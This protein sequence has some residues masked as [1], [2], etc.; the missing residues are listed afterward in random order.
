MSVDLS[1]LQGI[2]SRLE[3]VADRLEKGSGAPA[4]AATST[5]AVEDVPAIVSAWDA[6]LLEKANPIK[7]AADALGVADVS[8]ATDY[9]LRTTRLARDVFAATNK[10]RKPKD[11]EWQKFLAPVMEVNSAASKA[12]DNRSE[13]FGNRKA[14]AEAMGF[15]MMVTA[16]NPG[17]FAQ[18]ALESMDFHAI[19]VLQKKNPPETAWI[20]ALKTCLKGLTEWCNENCKL[21][22][23][24]KHDGEDPVA[25]FA[26]QPL[27]SEAAG[28]PKAKGK[29]KG[30]P[31][32]PQGGFKAPPKEY[33]E[34]VQNTGAP[35]AAASGA[36]MSDVFSAITE[37]GTGGLKKV[38]DDMKCK[39]RKDEPVK[40]VV[41][42]KAAAARPSVVARFAKGPKGPPLKELQKDVNW[43]IEN[44]DGDNNV[45]MTEDE[46]EMK[47]CICIINCRNTTVK[48]GS[49]VKAITLDGCEKVN[50]LMKDVISVVEL[51]NSD[52]SQI[53]VADGKVK[54]LA[55]DKCNGVQIFLNKESADCEIVTSK[56]SEMNVNIPDPDST[57]PLDMIE[58]PIP[59]QFVTTI[60]GKKTKTVVSSLYS[61]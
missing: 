22:L 41:K 38:T 16:P 46:V 47:H 33:L 6:F 23:T 50:V 54:M 14:G 15:F 56:S 27:G 31:P 12:C 1:Q 11:D 25:Y 2:L 55:I 51:V 29:G 53:Q 43:V 58:I 18:Q 40:E 42:P 13:F 28:A 48:L 49:R 10:C 19:K 32:V 35:V 24:W 37:K 45:V 17:A 8:E 20:N 3:T 44:Y 59:E 36:G 39:N 34:A 60:N 26:A 4:G 21:G 57:D 30:A 52:R 61:D 7:V 9:F 5:S